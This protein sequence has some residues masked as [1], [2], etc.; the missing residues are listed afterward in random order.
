MVNLYNLTNVSNSQDLSQLFVAV[1]QL[2]GGSF[3]TV[4]LIVFWI[5]LDVGLL[6]WGTETSLGVSSF[7]AAILAGFLFLMGVLPVQILVVAWL[8][9]AVCLFIMYKKSSD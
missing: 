8:F 3:A 1:N 2:S 6:R 4:I 9:A 7:A 5:I